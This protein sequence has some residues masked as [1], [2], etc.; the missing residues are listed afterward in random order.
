MGHHAQVRLEIRAFSDA[1]I[2]DAAALLAAR[3]RGHRRDAPGLDPAFEDPA[4]AR[5]ELARLAGV[6]GASGA[7]AVRGGDCFGYLLGVPRD[8]DVWGP[9]AWV[10]SAGHATSEPELARDLYRL[11][12]TRWRAEGRSRHYV[13]VPATDRD[14]V[15]AW[16]ALG[17]GQQ[18]VHA[19]RRSPPASFRAATKGG[20]LVRRATRSDLEVLTRLDLVLPEH[21]AGSPVFSTLRIPD[22]GEV[23]AELERDLDDPRLTMLVAEREGRLVG[24]ATACSLELS[25]SNTGL[26]RPASAG[27]LGYA[28]VLPEA[29]GLGT[30]RALGEAV[31][32]WSR[33]AGYPWVATD[34]RATNLEA[35]R[36]WP[37]LGFRPTFLRLHRAIV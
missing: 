1:C 36:A 12:A 18:Q 29:R 19:L 31:L 32:V 7:I 9:N 27:F 20:L 37:R 2:D 26:I 25:S 14:L 10:E 30:G 8:A 11:A 28:A 22:P 13:V 21:Q 17:F 5:A 33:D 35:S 23:R 15:D 4:R 24:T 16:F 6:E 3:H 34:W